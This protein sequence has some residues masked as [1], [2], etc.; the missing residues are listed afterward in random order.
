[1]RSHGSRL[2]MLA[3]SALLACARPAPPRPPAPPP[4]PA[5]TTSPPGPTATTSPPVAAAPT[6]KLRLSPGLEPTPRLAVEI[7]A[8]G[9]SAREWQIAALVSAELRDLEVR[10]ERGPLAHAPR[11]DGVRLAVTLARAPVGPLRITYTLHPTEPMAPLPAD[12]PAALL[13]RIDHGRVLA[14]GEEALLLPLGVDEL[15]PWQLELGPVPPRLLRVVSSLGAEAPARVRAEQLRHAVFLIGPAGRAVFRGPEGDDDFAWTGEPGFDLRWSAAETAGARTAVDLYFGAA[16]EETARFTGILAV[17]IDFPGDTGARVVPRSGGLYVA[18]SPDARWDA[19]TRLAVAQGLVH[20]WIGGRLRLGAR[21]PARADAPPAADAWFADGFARFVAREVLFNLGTLS[22]D[23]YADELNLHHA[24]LATAP[25]RA[26]GN[27]EVA[28]AASAG[29][30]DAQALLVARGALY[31]TRIDA[32]IRGRHR[33]RSLRT[34][35]RELVA[36]ARREA[37]ADLPLV[38]F[39]DRLRAELGPAEVAAFERMVLAG[40]PLLLPA[41]ALGPCFTR[42]PRVYT[43]FELGLDAATSRAATPGQVCGVRPGGPAARAGVRDGERFNNLFFT[44][45]DPTVPATLTLERGGKDVEVTWRPVGVVAR[46]DAWRKR[47]NIDEARCT[48]S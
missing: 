34:L 40:G 6:L 41:D 42:G 43:R 3:G 11:R 13:L 14:S 47:P 16:P 33:D 23:D 38:A 19:R 18:L 2:A 7:V 28:A 35:L 36:Q 4:G 45:G 30:R 32:A 17:D 20:R 25:L 5:A 12:V 29:D 15:L 46:G 8:A 37:R 9:I 48:R 39:T 31:A 21:D 22:A 44:P 24:E 27:A 1:M 26:A 10:D